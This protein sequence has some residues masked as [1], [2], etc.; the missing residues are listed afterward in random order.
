MS[1]SGHN[2]FT[3]SSG[4]RSFDTPPAGPSHQLEFTPQVGHRDLSVTILAA[5]LLAGDNR[6]RRTVTKPDGCLPPVNML[7]ARSARAKRLEIALG[8]QLIVSLW[9]SEC[10]ESSIPLPGW[11][12]PQLLSPLLPENDT[13]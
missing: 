1:L 3:H 4:H 2:S 11:P 8:K 10:H 13:V 12:Q 7:T 9:Y 6:T 5:F